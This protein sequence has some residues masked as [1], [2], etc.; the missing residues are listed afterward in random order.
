MSFQKFLFKAIAIVLQILRLQKVDIDQSSQV[1][2]VVGSSL[3]GNKTSSSELKRNDESNTVRI[4]AWGE[5]FHRY[6]QMTPI[7]RK[8]YAFSQVYTGRAQIYFASGDFK[9]YHT[10]S[11]GHQFTIKPDP[12]LKKMKISLMSRGWSNTFYII[13]D[14]GLYGFGHN[15]SF[16]TE[17]NDD[18]SDYDGV[19]GVKVF[20][21]PGEWKNELITSP[22]QIPF[23]FSNNVTK[24]ESGG[25]FSIFLLDNGLV[26]GVGLNVG[27]TEFHRYITKT[28]TKING[29]SDIKDVACG[30]DQHVLCLDKDG[31]VFG[32]GDNEYGQLTDINNT[33][34]F[35]PH[36]SFGYLENIA[37]ERG[38]YNNKYNKPTI[39]QYFKKKYITI[40]NISCGAQHSAV[41]D[42]DGNV[43][44]F[45]FNLWG[46]IGDGKEER[47]NTKPFKIE[48]PVDN[49][50]Y[51]VIIDGYCTQYIL[52]LLNSNK[53]IPKT[54][55]RIC[56]DYYYGSEFNE[57]VKQ[58]VCTGS[59]TLLLCSNGHIY[60]CG[61]LWCPKK[62]K[63][64]R[65][66]KMFELD[67]KPY[68]IVATYS[69]LFFFVK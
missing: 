3:M 62:T 38:D 14:D 69:N 55:Q 51:D 21:Q 28:P 52:P 17:C 61:G 13:A 45:G 31:N 65:V 60:G 22:I 42:S 40:T 54:V 29:L 41:G 23:N 12:Y 35:S 43:Y 47:I 50:I 11:F 10:A 58:I 5:N 64:Q 46:A 59:S 56:L 8:D 25:S 16:T 32:F 26:F 30:R 63:M 9:I 34:I 36:Q 2:L 24:I 44:T 67:G 6:G 37:R 66:D 18:H 7:V 20:S 4:F 68:R 33:L 15:K 53:L 19:F 1:N 39:F 48:L 57:I 49:D 27:Y